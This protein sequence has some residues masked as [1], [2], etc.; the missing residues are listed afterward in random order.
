MVKFSGAL[1]DGFV[2]H[3]AIQ[4]FVK[5]VQRAKGTRQNV[6]LSELTLGQVIESVDGTLYT[7]EYLW[8]HDPNGPYTYV[9]IQP[10]GHSV[11]YF[12]DQDGL[13]DFLF[14]SDGVRSGAHDGCSSSD[15]DEGPSFSE[16]E[17]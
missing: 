13:D 8:R 4:V 1:V 14:Q 7:V 11:L 17:D 10:V 15:S 16:V 9:E 5:H 6:K 2:R 12:L 3:G